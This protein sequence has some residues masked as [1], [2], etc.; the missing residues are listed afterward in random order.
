MEFGPATYGLALLAGLLS[1]L[2][3]CVLPLIPVLI[4][5]AVS[6]HRWGALALGVGLTVSF[7]VVGFFIATV[8]ASLG[9]DPDT[10]RTAGAVA[11][12]IFGLILLVPRFQDIFARATGRV[13]ASGSTLLARIR[14]DG[15]C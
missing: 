4:A 11:L 14:G 3:P 5:A 12:V 9:L 13:S 7:T 6:V 1:T 2:S 15:R 8:G 10:F